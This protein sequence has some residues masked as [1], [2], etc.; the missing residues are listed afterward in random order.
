MDPLYTD[1]TFQTANGLPHP[2]FVLENLT[3]GPV[4]IE[5]RQ[6]VC[7]ACDDMAPLVKEILGIDFGKT[8]TFYKTI[9]IGNNNVTFIHI[10]HDHVSKELDDSFYI[11]DK[12]NVGGVPMFVFIT[13]G[14]NSGHI[15]PYYATAYGTLTLSN[16]EAR[17]AF[18]RN[19]LQDAIDH[20]NENIMGY[21]E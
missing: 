10:N 3:K 4:F 11:Y 5:Y 7:K 14:N 15:E 13:L 16:N 9:K 17:K 8:E 6:D 1:F 19:M 2:V 20:Y 21:I 12:N 18:L